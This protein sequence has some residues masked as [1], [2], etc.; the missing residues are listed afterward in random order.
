LFTVLVAHPSMLAF[1]LFVVL[2]Q[3]RNP[4]V[5]KDEGDFLA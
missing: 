1:Y 2:P 3:P 5:E 4:E